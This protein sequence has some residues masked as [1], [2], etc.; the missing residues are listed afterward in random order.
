MKRAG[1]CVTSAPPLPE[2]GWITSTKWQRPEFCILRVHIDKLRMKS[3]VTFHVIFTHG[4]GFIFKLLE[5]AACLLSTQ[6]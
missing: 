6:Q 2:H 4:K 5:H 1:S 3:T